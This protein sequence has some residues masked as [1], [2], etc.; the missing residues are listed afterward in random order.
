M[1]SYYTGAHGRGFAWDR[2]ISIGLITP[3]TAALQVYLG[4]YGW[5]E[6]GIS[7]N[8]DAT[9]G[10]YGYDKWKVKF[11][12]AGVDYLTFSGDG[13]GMTSGTKFMIGTVQWTEAGSDSMNG[14]MLAAGS[15]LDKALAEDYKLADDPT[16]NLAIPSADG[17]YSGLLMTAT[18]GE[19]LSFGNLCYLKSDGKY[20]KANASAASTMPGVVMAL[21]SVSADASGSFLTQG[22]IRE[23][24]WNWTTVGAM[25][26][27]G[28]TAGTVTTTR[29][30]DAGDQVQGIGRVVNADVIYFMPSLVVVE[31]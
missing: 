20:W 15:V 6:T 4:G 26:W 27:A 23:D 18:A 12:S 24:D 29:P 5:N 3:G 7:L 9:T 13:I 21:G 1:T 30:S 19:N 2:P 22:M 25:I 10:F 28:E 31:I 17:G 8:E 16:T 11:R 14:Q